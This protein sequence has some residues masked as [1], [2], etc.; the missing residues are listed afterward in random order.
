MN[1]TT[2]STWTRKL[3]KLRNTFIAIAQFKICLEFDAFTAL[4]AEIANTAQAL[5]ESHFGDAAARKDAEFIAIAASYEREWL[6]ENK[7]LWL[8]GLEDEHTQVLRYNR[9]QETLGVEF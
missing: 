9:Y 6:I 5:L 7:K 4:F 2:K 1:I 3:N 8:E